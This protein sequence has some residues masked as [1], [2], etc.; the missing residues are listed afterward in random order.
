[1]NSKLTT[2]WMLGVLMAIVLA[3]GGVAWGTLMSR[4]DRIETKVE[5]IQREYGRI[6]AI[7]AQVDAQG[8]QLDRMEGVLDDLLRGRP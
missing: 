8:K 4:I 1:M 2:G 3:L 5:V 6:G 7:Q